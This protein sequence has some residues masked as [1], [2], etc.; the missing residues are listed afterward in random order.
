MEYSSTEEA[1]G[2]ARFEFFRRLAALAPDSVLDVGCGRG[3]TLLRC[4]EAGIHAVGVDSTLAED[5]VAEE[6]DLRVASATDLPFEDASFDWVSMRY[7]PHHLPNPAAA[8]REALRVARTG[9][10]VAE[11]WFDTREGT[12]ETALELDRW[13]KRQDRRGGMVH[14]D[15]LGERELRDALDKATSS[16]LAIECEHLFTL[17][18]RNLADLLPDLEAKKADLPTDHPDHAAFARL[19]KRIEAEG[20]SWNGSLFLTVRHSGRSE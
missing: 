12:Q 20:L 17:R 2:I 11:P 16:P 4:R 1:V 6:L 19:R 10:F 7:V 3:D 9:F 14:E 13:V 18:A 15:V 5:P 8:F